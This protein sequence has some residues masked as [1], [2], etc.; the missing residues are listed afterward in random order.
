MEA[1]KI[2][3]DLKIKS[4][5]NEKEINKKKIIISEKDLVDRLYY[6]GKKRVELRNLKNRQIQNENVDHYSFQPIINK[7][8][9]KEKINIEDRLLDIGK[10]YKLKREKEILEKESKELCTFTPT[11]ETRSNILGAKKRKKRKEDLSYDKILINPKYLILKPSKNSR[12]T[13]YKDNN[14]YI[15]DNESYSTSRSNIRSK[16]FNRNI[17]VI[18]LNPI[19]NFYDLLYVEARTLKEKKRKMREKEFNKIYTFKPDLSHSK[20]KYCFSKE[21]NDEIINR[22]YKG[23]SRAAKLRNGLNI[24]SNMRSKSADNY[25]N[26]TNYTFRPVINRGPKNLNNQK[27]GCN[28]IEYKI[29]SE[30]NKLAKEKENK[31]TQKKKLYH[32]ATNKIINNIKGTNY[33][34]MFNK[35]DSDGD[36][37]ISSNKICIAFIDQITLEILTPI[38]EELQQRQIIMNEIEFCKKAEK[39]FEEFDTIEKIKY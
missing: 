24:E 30:N 10:Q 13:Y 22:L 27:S 17:P 19:N 32:I 38:L 37:K 35:L 9:N 14:S 15:S 34:E 33:K 5:K 23:Y 16:I 31:N 39:C 29:T 28:N 36:G 1:D 7:S 18:K 12:N 20:V 8:I 25:K 6:Q 4:N 3:Y 21:T 2:N 11:L 26:K